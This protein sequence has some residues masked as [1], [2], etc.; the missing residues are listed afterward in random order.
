M[1]KVSEYFSRLGL[2]SPVVVKY[3]TKKEVVHTTDSKKLLAIGSIMHKALPED[4]IWGVG[5]AGFGNIFKDLKVY[6]VRG[7][8]TREILL[9]N[10]T[11]RTDGWLLVKKSLKNIKD[12]KK[13]RVILEQILPG[14]EK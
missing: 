5:Y 7:P 6:A 3:I 14:I 12:S 11:Q 13:A 10:E 4:I 1:P 9:K 8:N 2:L